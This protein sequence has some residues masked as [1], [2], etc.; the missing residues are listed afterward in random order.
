MEAKTIRG[1][2]VIEEYDKAITLYEEALNHLLRSCGI[3]DFRRR[4]R[5][6]LK[7]SFCYSI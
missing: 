2:I 5:R 6:P 7:S 3:N 1:S 4:F